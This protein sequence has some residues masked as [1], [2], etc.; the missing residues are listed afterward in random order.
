MSEDVQ[1]VNVTAKRLPPLS[2]DV[3]ILVDGQQLGGWTD[4]HIV[5]GLERMPSSFDLTATDKYP[6]NAQAMQ[7]RPGA[8]CQV[9]IGSDVVVTGYVDRVMPSITPDSHAV[10]LSGRGKCCDLV[11]C[12]AEWPGSQISG[13]NVFELAIKLCA[14]YGINV[15]GKG[16]MGGAIPKYSFGVG[17]TAWSIIEL[18]TR[19]RQLVT[20]ERNDGNLQLLYAATQTGMSS[21]FAPAAS[22]FAEGVNIESATALWDTAFRYSEYRCHRVSIEPLMEAGAGGNVVATT[23]DKGIIRHRRFSFVM[24]Q[25]SPLGLDAGKQR[26]QWESVRRFGRAGQVRLT[27]DAWR[28]ADGKLYDIGTS[29]QLDAPSLK[30]GVDAQP[31]AFGLKSAGDPW[32]ISEIAYP[33]GWRGHARGHHAHAARGVRPGAHDPAAVP[34]PGRSGRAA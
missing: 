14:P 33:Q 29:V 9:M 4:V 34:R 11:D 13:A 27:T 16:D 7:I 20:Y 12:S 23:F 3:T 2:E 26:A 15:E 18:W 31:L 24:E 28:D 6:L 19:V 17:E 30:V 1:V 25:G 8:E 10:R 32:V 21:P 5:R 22:G